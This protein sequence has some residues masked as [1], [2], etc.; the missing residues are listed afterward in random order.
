MSL[1]HE[2]KRALRAQDPGD[3]FTA[4]V[5]DA[6][7]AGTK[8]DARRAATVDATGHI[9]GTASASEIAGGIASGAARASVEAGV[10]VAEAGA[11]TRVVTFPTPTAR[12]AEEQPAP[13]SREWF[14]A[15]GTPT[16]LVTKRGGAR[17]AWAAAIAATL[18]LTAG[19]TQWVKSRQE[20]AEGARARAEVLAALRLTS[21]KLSI[22]R[23]AVTES[24]SAH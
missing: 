4:R 1:E 16:H 14:L 21:A 17:R 11:G 8:A 9:N 2:L 3:A 15:D 20:L 19:G 22:V 13:A 6:V 24:E 7:K 18:L 12:P 23:A 5:L 10:D